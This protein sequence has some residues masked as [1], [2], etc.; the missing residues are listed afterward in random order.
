VHYL[1]FEVPFTQFSLRDPRSLSK[2][3]YEFTNLSNHDP[4]IIDVDN[5]M[6]GNYKIPYKGRE[7]LD[8]VE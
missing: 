8:L 3:N 6:Q 5:F 7:S 1:K 2:N 4:T